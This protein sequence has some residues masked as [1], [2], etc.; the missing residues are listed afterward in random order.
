MIKVQIIYSVVCS[1]KIYFN[2]TFEVA[3]AVFESLTHDC[4]I[5][6]SEIHITEDDKNK[7]LTEISKYYDKKDGT[8]KYG[9]T[10]STSEDTDLFQY[11][12]AKIRRG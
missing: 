5:R 8:T 3:V 12:K 7:M 9:L 6:E 11:Y 10:H 4:K 1:K 2:L